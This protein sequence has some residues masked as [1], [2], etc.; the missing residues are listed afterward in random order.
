MAVISKASR[1]GVDVKVELEGLADI[2]QVLNEVEQGV[3]NRVL[4]KAFRA[5]GR[6][7]I[8][9]A[10]RA[11]PVRSR[12]LRRSIGQK[13]ATYK[14]GTM[15]LV[16]GPRRGVTAEHEGR[17]VV[18]ANYAHLVEFGTQRSRATPFMRQAAVAARSEGV[19]NFSRKIR[20]EL[21]KEVEKAVARRLKRLQK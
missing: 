16:V 1:N 11:A 21:P 15:V 18:P 5:Y 9:P 6:Q 19:R 7:I 20:E 13:I 3:R 12:A 2:V 8:K 10:K 14:S 17:R 4:R